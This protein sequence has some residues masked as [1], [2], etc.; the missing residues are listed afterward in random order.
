MK[1][2]Y[3]T[4]TGNIYG[5]TIKVNSYTESPPDYS[6]DASDWDARGGEEIDFVITDCKQLDEIT[7]GWVYVFT[8]DDL[9]DIYELVLNKYKEELGGYL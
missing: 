3:M 7:E 9:D 1:I 4:P 5:L 2:T 8:E 6:S